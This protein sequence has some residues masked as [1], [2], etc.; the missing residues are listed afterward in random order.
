MS[1]SV[2]VLRFTRQKRNA[3]EFFFCHPVRML[4][5][6]SKYSLS[7]KIQ[8]RNEK[9]WR[10]HIIC[11]LCITAEDV[12]SREATKTNSPFMWYAWQF[13]FVSAVEYSH[14]S[15]FPWACEKEVHTIGNGGLL[16]FVIET[17]HKHRKCCSF[18]CAIIYVSINICVRSSPQ[19]MRCLVWGVHIL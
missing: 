12:L 3:Q 13:L 14:F 15:T 16:L 1:S 10:S 8:M 17:E 19:I 11:K 18:F 5:S 4:F 2:D 9:W 6:R 7:L